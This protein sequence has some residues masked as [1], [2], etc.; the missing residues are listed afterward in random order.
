M[1]TRYFAFGCS[2]V[3]SRWATVAD[4]I[5]ANFDE[6]RNLGNAGACN[7]FICNR[8]I[9]ADSIFNFNSE[10][11]F[12]TVGVTGFG[13]FSYVDKDANVWITSGDILI[14]ND[15]RPHKTQFVAKE[16]DSY[17]YAVYRSWV[18]IK[19]ISTI[20]K[21][22]NV[23]H[24]IY[25]NVD[26][27]LF[28]TDY[29]L[30]KATIDKIHDIFD[31]CHVKESLDEFIINNGSPRGIKYKDGGSDS[32]PSQ[33]QHYDYLKNHFSEFDT[34]KTKTRFEYLESIFDYESMNTQTLNI[35]KF[36]KNTHIIRDYLVWS[37]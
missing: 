3:N 10:T 11:D 4:L 32:H 7:T 14:W 33:Q 21:S 22:K 8:F 25:P 6:Y 15:N 18:G 17:A 23:K 34:D 28:L 1:A 30:P 20:L 2:Y 12:V 26:N 27:L 36:F 9:E 29:N 35:N 13:R 24:I 31:M 16:L 5:G 19:T 37:P